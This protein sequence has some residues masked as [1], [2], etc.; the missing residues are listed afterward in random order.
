M[1][2][3][4][5]RQSESRCGTI[6]VFTQTLPVWVSR[7]L[8]LLKPDC[9]AI[10]SFRCSFRSV[11]SNWSPLSVGPSNRYGKGRPAWRLESWMLH[12]L[13]RAWLLA[14]SDALLARDRLALAQDQ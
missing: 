6:P 13:E 2:S 12:G 5:M 10:Q 7:G 8:T 3:R 4:K 1:D 9:C 14:H 11:Q